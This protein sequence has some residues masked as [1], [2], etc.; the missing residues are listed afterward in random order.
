M[1]PH[2]WPPSYSSSSTASSATI[3]T[4]LS[5]TD[6]TPTTTT[7][8]IAT[9][10]SF[11]NMSS[12]TPFLSNTQTTSPTSSPVAASVS[13]GSST[14]NVGAIAGGVIGGVVFL[15]LLILGTILF[16]R[17]R[18][19]RHIA[20]SSEFADT[21]KRGEMP[22]L[23]LDNGIEIIPSA[24]HHIPLPLRQDSYHKSPPMSEMKFPD[25]MMWS[26]AQ[27]ARYSLQKPLHPLRFPVHQD[28][29]DS[30]QHAAARSS[31]DNSHEYWLREP[32]N[33]EIRREFVSPSP[34]PTADSGHHPLMQNT[35]PMEQS[36]TVETVQNAYVDLWKL[37]VAPT[38]QSRPISARYNGDAQALPPLVPVRRSVDVQALPPLVPVRR[39]VDV[40]PR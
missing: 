22:V 1:S 28:S 30:M 25:G 9:T 18:R 35:Y 2:N 4:P 21:I 11:S 38:A 23:R 24:T 39:S 29:D 6:D 5:S 3:S 14:V 40:G 36:H 20:P 7:S 15:A 10:L 33:I 34:P 32:G 13:S 31:V 16:C 12:T 37:S 17:S 8:S 27:S 19:R 26:E